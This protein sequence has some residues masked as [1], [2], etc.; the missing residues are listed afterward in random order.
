M[1]SRFHV[2]GREAV[3]AAVSGKSG[4]MMAFVRK[5]ADGS[6]PYEIGVTDVD[7]SASANRVKIV[8]NEFITPDGNASI[9]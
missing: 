2:I 4:R 8:P 7:V 5:N 1:S 6:A 9:I 3:K